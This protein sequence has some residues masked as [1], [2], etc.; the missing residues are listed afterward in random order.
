[1]NWRGRARSPRCC[2]PEPGS[3]IRLCDQVLRIQALDD[4]V[5]EAGLSLTA[6]R[7]GGPLLFGR[8]WERLG[9]DAVLADLLKDR[10]FE[11]AVER[12]VFVATLHRL[13]VSGSD[14][15]CATWM[16]DYDVPG[17]EGIG[18]DHFYRA[19]AWLGEEIEDSSEDAPSPRCVKDL[20]EEKLFE[21]RRDLFTDLSAVFMDTTSLSFYGEGGETLGE[22]GYSK[23]YRPDLKQMILGLVVDGDGR[24]ICT[25]MG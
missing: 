25:E 14:R 6:K 17:V 10:A 16:S 2:P 18:L 9:I 11:F 21:R 24:P 15:D 19:M 3:A 13:F 12:A 1:M 4:N 23:D 8:I 20:I 5:D 22:R 7:I